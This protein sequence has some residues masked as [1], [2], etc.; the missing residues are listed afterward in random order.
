MLD[1]KVVLVTGGA[2]LIG[3]AFCR[4]IADQG[5]LTV[6]ADR[7]LGAAQALAELIGGQT[8]AIALD[9]TDPASVTAC[10]DDVIGS[11]GGLDGLVN[12]AYPRN[13]NYGRPVEEVAYE[14]FCENLSL[15]L[16][17]Y[18]LMMQQAAIRL[19]ACGGGTI[20][21]M[22]SVYGVVPPRFEIYAGTSMTMPVEYAATKA[23]ILHLTRYF[24]QA[25]KKA[26]VRVNAL[27]PG[28]IEDEQPESFLS[29]YRALSG[30][31]G[32]LAPGDLAGS[33]VYL[34]S[35]HARHVTGQNLIVD[36][37]FTL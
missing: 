13:A 14:D 18:F 29:A 19:A 6:V 11:A 36:D 5:G 31:T 23:G 24:A 27:S 17:G 22:S 1:D 25:Y 26:G 9:I 3:R 20:I 7:D 2:G 8:R 4:A 16:G 32:M 12:N 21:N 15:H 33:L 30:Q 34:L 10:L 37:G 28:G 35:D